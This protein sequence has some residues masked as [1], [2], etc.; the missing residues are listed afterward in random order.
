MIINAVSPSIACNIVH[1][2]LFDV[3]GKN[4]KEKFSQGD[5]VRVAVL[6]Q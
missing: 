4:L 5:L 6:Q 1:V 2:E 3:V